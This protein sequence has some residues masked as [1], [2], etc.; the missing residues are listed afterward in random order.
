MS[1]C[2]Y[3]KAKKKTLDKRQ[4]VRDASGA[5]HREMEKTDLFILRKRTKEHLKGCVLRFSFYQRI[6]IR[7]RD[8][9]V[10]AIYRYV[11][12]SSRRR[13][14]LCTLLIPLVCACF[15]FWREDYSPFFPRLMFDLFFFLFVALFSLPRDV[16][17]F[18]VWTKEIT[19]KT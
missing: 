4:H 5:M 2:V 16:A 3:K 17:V 7:E 15:C 8:L 18:I 11:F 1:V 14:G 10:S 6:R 19:K 12:E 9:V 13:P